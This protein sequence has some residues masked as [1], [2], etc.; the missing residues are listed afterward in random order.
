[1]AAEISVSRDDID[2][3]AAW[4]VIRAARELARMLAHELAHLEISPVEF[5]VLAQL[6]AGDGLSQAE[7]ARSVGVRPQSMTALVSGLESRTLIARGSDRGR[8]RLSQIR[9]TSE[10]R[11]LLARAYP[12]V[13]ASNGWFGDDTAGVDAIRTTLMPLLGPTSEP[14]RDV[15]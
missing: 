12:V 2:G 15:P 8:G 11:A 9:L 6:A 3:I 1:M 10:G 14:A 5:G 4:T 13:R 7:L